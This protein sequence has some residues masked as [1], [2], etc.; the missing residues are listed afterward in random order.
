[1]DFSFL[2][3]RLIALAGEPGAA[4]LGGLA[5]GVV[6]GVAAQQSRFCLRA[7]TVEFGR[8]GFGLHGIGPRS[9]VWLLTF[10][11]A[12]FWTQALRALGLLDLSEARM[13]AVPG[14]I[15]GAIIGGLMFGAG[16]VLARGC[17]GRMLVLAATGN[18]RSL[19]S[20]LV[21]A[22]TAQ[23]SLRGLLAPLR[24][25]IAG[26]WT[27]ASLTGGRNIEITAWLG[28]GDRAGL[29]LGSLAAAVALVFALR[30][31]VGVKV[32]VMASGV[33]F[34]IPLAWAFTA[35]LSRQSF[36]PVTVEAITF[37]G[38]SAGLLMFV[39]QA[40]HELNFQTGLVPG[41]FLGAFAAALVTGELQLQGFEGAA[42]MR[43][44]LTGAALMG[45][46]GMLAGGCAIGAGVSGTS[47]FALTAWIALT[48]MW[49]GAMATDA[50]VDAPAERAAAAATQQTR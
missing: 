43:R 49:I 20:G 33:G 35:A 11:T 2:T 12:L 44:Y 21:F 16:M 15:S 42:S 7:A 29:V 17:S 4:A 37:T 10:G 26:W 14:S 23:M 8:G 27:T 48:G 32:L 40:T 3:E 31:R 39:L 34:A 9:S 22:V 5:I 36:D 6:F 45:M 13:L 25:E 47:V 24:A 50:L 19:L 38:P 46:G 1:M 30:N 41:V 18:L 28:L